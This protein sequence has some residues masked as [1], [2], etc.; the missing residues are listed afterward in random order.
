ME[1]QYNKQVIASNISQIKKRV[2]TAAK[3]SG[4]T[5]DDIIIMA[6]T[7]TVP[8]DAVNVAIEN[9]LHYLGENRVQE[10]LFKY[11]SYDLQNATVHFIGRLQT[12][13]VKYIADKVKMIHSVDSLKL[14]NEINKQCEKINKVMDILIEINVGSEDSKGGITPEDT[15][16][17]IKQVSQLKFIK[18]RGLMAIPPSCEDPEDTRKYFIL[19]KKLFVD[20]MGK[21][22]DN[23]SMDFLSMGMSSD[24]DIAIECGANIVRIGTSLFGGRKY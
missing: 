6:V 5:A 13:K 8:A 11:E 16:D 22:L 15:L 2:E 18:I 23:I 4:R 7:K 1:N 12:N 10:L 17:F 21:K 3:K 20:I 14:A 19:M 9:G 24:Y